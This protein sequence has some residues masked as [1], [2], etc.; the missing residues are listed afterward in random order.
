MVVGSK[1]RLRPVV[2]RDILKFLRWFNDPDVIEYLDLTLPLTEVA[3]REWLESLA[4]RRD[5]LVFV[6][7]RLEDRSAIGTIGLN[8]I[9][10]RHRHALLGLTV[11]EKDEWGKGFGTDAVRAIL[12]YAFGSLDLHKI[13]LHV[14]ADHLPAI[15]VYE[16]CGFRREGFLRREKLRR[17]EYVDEL[18]MAILKD[19]WEQP[20]VTELAPEPVLLVP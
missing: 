20:R 5:I 1:V 6:I 19:E 8:T 3:E 15:R 14:H 11:G 12:A 2:Q 10:G 9:D 16:K 7:E 18:V 17:G 4:E 13:S